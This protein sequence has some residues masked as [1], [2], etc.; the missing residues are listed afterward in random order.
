MEWKLEFNATPIKTAN[1]FS[2]EISANYATF[3]EKL[4]SIYGSDQSVLLNDHYYQVGDRLDAIYGYKFYRSPDGQ[5]INVGGTP[6]IPTQGTN[7]KQLLGYANP[8]FT[9]GIHNKFSYKDF[10]LGFQFDGRVGG[11]IYDEIYADMLQSG[12]AT[13]LTSGAMGAARLAEWNE[14]KANNYTYPA[15]FQ[16]QYTAPGVTV[17]SG[18][19]TFDAKGNI[20]NMS[21]LTFAPNTTKVGLK[22][23]VGTIDGTGNMQEPFMIS[24][25]YAMLRDLTFTY[26]LPKSL[27]NGL[28][29]KR[30]SFSLVGRN[31]LYLTAEKRKDTYLDQYPVGFDV[32]KIGITKNQ[33]VN[34]NGYGD[35]NVNLVT[36]AG[37]QTPVV[38][39]YGFNLN[40]AF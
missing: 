40:V 6:L 10:S 3:T 11:R 27:L 36:N 29:I 5:V 35:N 23:Y 16:G 19:P 14:V 32:S 20:T 38:R 21:S 28:F 4:K 7:Y 18:K 13:D 8:D 24:K 37:M 22:A 17:T 15:N 9:W 1:G 2:W 31:L 26:N 34:S 33:A 12:N 39:Q 30:A 25:S